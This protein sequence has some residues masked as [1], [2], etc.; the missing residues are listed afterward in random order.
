MSK[1]ECCFLLQGNRQLPVCRLALERG[2]IP[3]SKG[4][5]IYT[6][7]R[8]LQDRAKTSYTLSTFNRHTPSNT[9]PNSAIEK[10]SQGTATSLFLFLLV[11]IQE[12]MAGLLSLRRYL[13][14]A[15]KINIK[16]TFLTSLHGGK[17]T[18]SDI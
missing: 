5:F 1:S 12:T 4:F 6:D 9:T 11:N 7:I 13:S 3:F 15:G 10:Q 16:N 2:E 17:C 8:K 18:F 14:N